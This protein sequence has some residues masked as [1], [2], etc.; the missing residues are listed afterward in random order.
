MGSATKPVYVAENGVATAISHSINSDVPANA[1]FT[2]TTYSDAT[3][4]T[5]GLMSAADKKKLDEMDLTKYLPKS[6]GV[7]TGAI[8]TATNGVDITV[9]PNKPNSSSP[10]LVAGGSYEVPDVPTNTLKN[11]KSLIGTYHNTKTDVWFNMISVRHR[12]GYNDGANYGMYL[13]SKLTSTGNLIW[14]KQIAANTWQG[15]RT[16]LDS[17]NFTDYALAKDG[18]A[19]KAELL[20]S[21]QMRTAYCH[22]DDATFS[23]GYIWFKIGTATLS[24]SYATVSTTFLGICGFGKH[25]L[26]TARV[27]LTSAGNAVESIAF[28]ESGRTGVMQT[29]LFRIVAINGDKNVTFELWAKVANQYEGTRVV[30]LDGMNLA[31]ANQANFWTLTNG[32]NADS[33]TSPTTGD[34]HADSSDNSICATATKAETLTDSGWI[35]PTFPS[36]IKNSTIRYRKQGKIVSVSGYVIF[37]EATS[38]KVVLTLP[39]GYRPPAKIQQFNAVD[40]SAQASFLFTIDTNGKVSFV[41]KTQGF[42][43]TTSS[44]YIHCTFF[45]D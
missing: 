44:Y 35:I 4:S 19:K 3:E 8:D 34:M 37:S 24:G 12:N 33:K 41:G 13:F 39:E 6:G 25:A 18:T 38:A 1:K 27:R 42:F 40:S 11:Y 43:D 10:T 28:S 26:Y 9:S 2:D 45:V 23:N 22:N 36:G 16:L 21:G 31:G 15:D 14:N 29:G 5:H 20:S 7:M 17:V 32:R 30:I